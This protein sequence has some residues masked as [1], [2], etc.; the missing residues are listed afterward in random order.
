MVL[1]MQAIQRAPEADLRPPFLLPLTRK[2]HIEAI[3]RAPYILFSDL[4]SERDAYLSGRPVELLSDAEL[5]ELDSLLDR[6]LA[7]AMK[8][9]PT[10]FA[11]P[12]KRVAS[13]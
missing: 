7:M 5:V 4:V 9:G 2:R 11:R 10:F 13:A 8:R 12:R 1:M 3:E 6:V